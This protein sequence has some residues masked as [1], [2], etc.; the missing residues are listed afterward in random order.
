MVVGLK[1]SMK[2]EEAAGEVGRLAEVG[3]AAPPRVIWLVAGFEVDQLVRGAPQILVQSLARPTL[4][5]WP[6]HARGKQPP[7]TCRRNRMH[8]VDLSVLL[9]WIFRGNVPP[10]CLCMQHPEPG[11][12][13][14]F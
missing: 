5:Y 7:Y 13:F 4:E 1:S 14:C 8:P 10:V 3:V 6:C 11:I 9:E 12:E 2:E